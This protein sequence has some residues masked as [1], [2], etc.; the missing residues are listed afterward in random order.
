MTDPLEGRRIALAEA[1]ELDLLAGMLERAGAQAVRCPLVSIVDTPDAAP[2]EAWIRRAIAG[3]FDDVIL[4]TGEGV[5]RLLGFAD[6]ARLRADF[7]AALSRMRKIT[8]GPKPV[9]ALREIGLSTDL[10][11]KQPTT[12][13]IIATLEGETLKTRTVGVQL[14][15]QEPNAALIDFLQG[16][17]AAVDTVAPYIYASAADDERVAT[18]IRDMAAGRIDAIAF[19]S[20]PQIQRLAQVAEKA[21][22]AAALKDGF[23]RTKTAAIGPVVAKE[24]E[25]FGVRPDATVAP[26]YAMKP[27]VTAIARLFEP[28]PAR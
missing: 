21:G 1:R 11:A 5:R 12:A 27:L 17:G 26:P 2:V 6:R 18:L 15:G 13:G 10:A 20:S 22:L 19:T 24:L 7:V 23:G 28:A 4:Y 16:R 14:Y 9:R 8:R 3:G 25:R